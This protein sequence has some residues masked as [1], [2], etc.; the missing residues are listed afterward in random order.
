MVAAHGSDYA[1]LPRELAHHRMGASESTRTS[2]HSSQGIGRSSAVKITAHIRRVQVSR[3]S[4]SANLSTCQSAGICTASTRVRRQ[5]TRSRMRAFCRFILYCVVQHTCA[6]FFEA[7][8]LFFVAAEPGSLI[9][10][11]F[12]ADMIASSWRFVHLLELATSRPANQLWID[13]TVAR[14]RAVRKKMVALPPRC[15]FLFKQRG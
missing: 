2:Q 12:L 3:Q 14:H 1:R 4:E 8:R 13:A 10:A 6:R 9:N 15:V 5:P 7:H 11:C